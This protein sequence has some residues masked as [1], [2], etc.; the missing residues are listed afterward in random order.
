MSQDRR[1]LKDIRQ[2]A[3]SCWEKICCEKES[4]ALVPKATINEMKRGKP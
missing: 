2:T 4:V 1:F 3:S